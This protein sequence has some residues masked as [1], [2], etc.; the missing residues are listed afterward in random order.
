MQVS[1]PP[2]TTTFDQCL[3]SPNPYDPPSDDYLK[4]INF[5]NQ[6]FSHADTSSYQNLSEEELSH[7]KLAMKS[8]RIIKREQAKQR[9]KEKVQLKKEVEVKEE[10]ERSMRREDEAE[11]DCEDLSEKDKRK[12]QQKIRNRVSAQQSRD[13]KKVYIVNLEQQNA[14]LMTENSLLK[15]DVMFLKQENEHLKQENYYLKTQIPRKNTED[16][17][18]PSPLEAS[19]ESDST[20]PNYLY[21]ETT[22]NSV[23]SSPLYNNNGGSPKKL[24]KYGMALLTIIS[25]VMVFGFGVNETEHTVNV[26]KTQEVG[27]NLMLADGN[28]NADFMK[29]SEHAAL[30]YL[31]NYRREIMNKILVAEETNSTKKKNSLARVENE[32]QGKFL[33]QKNE[34]QLVLFQDNPD[35]PVSTLFCPKTYIFDSQVSLLN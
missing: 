14:V 15:Q 17:E 1:I 34:T 5:Q 9:A 26:Y 12:M 7:L 33:G 8:K 35:H 3:S 6:S 2:P 32:K 22:N 18:N 30:K 25:L 24:F 19:L 29:F 4:F 27:T 20:N 11:E 21:E 23:Y 16:N 10:S 31:K 28:Q 13:R